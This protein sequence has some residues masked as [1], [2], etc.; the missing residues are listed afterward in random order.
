[1]MRIFCTVSGRSLLKAGSGR[2][3][4]KDL[5]CIFCSH[6]SECSSYSLHD[7]SL[8]TFRQFIQ[9][10]IFCC[11]SASNQG[12]DCSAMVPSKGYPSCK[13]LAI[14]ALNRSEYACIGPSSS[15]TRSCLK[16]RALSILQTNSAYD[17]QGIDKRELQTM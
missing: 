13:R 12:W 4:T 17:R 14:D 9:F 5:L 6:Q 10:Y 11:F 8:V 7:I 2:P 16:M 15:I 3:L 1:M